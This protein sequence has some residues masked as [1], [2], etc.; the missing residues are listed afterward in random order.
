M[1]ARG[2]EADRSKEQAAENGEG[3][4]SLSVSTVGAMR[5][6]KLDEFCLLA[7][8]VE[9][10]AFDELDPVAWITRAETYFEV[11]RISEGIRIQ[12]AKLS[13][14]GATIHWFNIWKESTD[15]VSWESFKDALIGRFGR[16]RLDNPYEELKELRQRG[17]VDEYIGKFELYSSQCGKIP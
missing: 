9:L 1:I 4:E 16:G 2:T 11:Q 12:L 10:P 7:K 13:M 8:K 6:D 17:M 5:E 15:E 3:P 14:E